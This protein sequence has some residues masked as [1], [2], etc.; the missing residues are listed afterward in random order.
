MYSEEQKS[1]PYLRFQTCLR[2]IQQERDYPRLSC[3]TGF[4][5]RRPPRPSERIS[6]NADCPSRAESTAKP[7]TASTPPRAAFRRRYAARCRPLFFPRA[8][9][10]APGTGAAR[11][12]CSSSYSP[13]A[14]PHY[15]N[16]APVPLTGE[17]DAETAT[18]VRSCR[19]FSACRRPACGPRDMGHARRSPQRT[20]HAHA[21]R[22]DDIEAAACR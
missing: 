17:Y 8:A 3:R 6:A 4:T 7:G 2:R 1:P 5:A 14:A 18:A 15:A 21:A 12:S 13:A 11:F 9:S 19:A 16:T 22:M 10:L 20:F